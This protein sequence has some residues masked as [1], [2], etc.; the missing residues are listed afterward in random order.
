[1]NMRFFSIIDDR[2]VEKFFCQTSSKCHLLIQLWYKPLFMMWVLHCK[3]VWAILTL[4][5][6]LQLALFVC[7]WDND[8]RVKITK[9]FAVG[10]CWDIAGGRVSYSCGETIA[11]EPH[12]CW[13]GEHSSDCISQWSNTFSFEWWYYWV[14]GTASCYCNYHHWPES[15]LIISQNFQWS[16]CNWVWPSGL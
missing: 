12:D 11:G 6:L 4:P 3:N 10:L 8:G 5:L 13:F 16:C 15:Q 2:D 7:N 9:C 1:M 14:C